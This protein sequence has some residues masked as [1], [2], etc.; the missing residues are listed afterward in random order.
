MLHPCWPE[1]TQGPTQAS[2][3][4]V[5]GTTVGN[6]HTQYQN[7]LLGGVG[8]R[9]V[10]MGGQT[11]ALVKLKK[12]TRS[13]K[14]KDR[15]GRPSFPRPPP[16][17]GQT[18]PSSVARPFQEVLPTLVQ[19]GLQRLLPLVDTWRMGVCGETRESPS[20]LEAKSMPLSRVRAH[21]APSWCHLARPLLVIA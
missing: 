11:A 1:E 2:E 15:E 4:L 12:R 20:R 6:P 18:M 10:R 21:L 3:G 16:V 13:T 9:G 14:K 8:G 17:S 5:R 19:A 7:E